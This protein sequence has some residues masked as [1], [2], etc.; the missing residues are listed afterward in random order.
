MAGLKE[1]GLGMGLQSTYP[2]RVKANRALSFGCKK[3]VA[4]K[5]DGGSDGAALIFFKN[6]FMNYMVSIEKKRS[7]KLYSSMKSQG[8]HSANHTQ[9]KK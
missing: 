7:T 4:V 6:L 1:G 5:S 9:A 8:K 2:P 3:G